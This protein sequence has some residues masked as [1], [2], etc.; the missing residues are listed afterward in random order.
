MSYDMMI[1][2]SIPLSLS[3]L[4]STVY[5]F[6]GLSLSFSLYSCNWLSTGSGSL[7]I[8]PSVLPSF[9]L[10]SLI[11]YGITYSFPSFDSH[12]HLFFLFFISSNQFSHSSWSNALRCLFIHTYRYVS[13]TPSLL[14]AYDYDSSLN[15]G[16]WNQVSFPSFVRLSC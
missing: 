4:Y 3:T 2:F 11:G 16:F 1:S 8:C 15:P 6:T 12:S 13:R 10:F 14:Y 7:L 5:D 9:P